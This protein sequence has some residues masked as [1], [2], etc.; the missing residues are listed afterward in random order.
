MRKEVANLETLHIQLSK[1]PKIIHISCHADYDSRM[2]QFFL[3]FEEKDTGILD[4]VTES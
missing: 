1:K 4:K 3:A 2:K